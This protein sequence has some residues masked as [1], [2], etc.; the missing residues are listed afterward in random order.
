[1]AME[2][3][4]MLETWLKLGRQ[5]TLQTVFYAGMDMKN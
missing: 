2:S 1:M 5:I 3:R 4:K